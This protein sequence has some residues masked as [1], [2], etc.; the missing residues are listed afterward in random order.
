MT[1]ILSQVPLPLAY[2]VGALL[3]TPANRISVADS[4]CHQRFGTQF[5]L[6]LCL[7]DTINDAYL[8]QAE[9]QTIQTIQTIYQK[10]QQEEFYLPRLFIRLRS[11]EQISTLLQPMGQAAELL[12][13]FIFPKFSLENA[14]AYL[15]ALEDANHVS[16]PKP[17]FM[18]PV[19]EDASLLS[20][21]SRGETLEQ[22]KD[23]LQPYYQQVLNIRVGCNDLCH[24]FGLRRQLHQTIYDI[25]PVANILSDILT[26]F[27]TDYVVSAPV[28]EYFQDETELWKTGLKRELELDLLNG[29]I[30]KTVIHPSQIAV[31]N[32]GLKVSPAD[33]ADACQILNWNPDNPYYVSGGAQTQ[34]MNEYKTHHRWAQRILLLAE[35][36]GIRQE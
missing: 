34:R 9:Q 31:V 17:F 10:R 25:L 36:Y 2:H 14:S 28:W 22:L 12:T 19:L 26:V 15:A 24:L 20:L 35:Y 5:S 29:F 23:L 33:Y 18:M 30:G 8:H 21:R 32:E 1:R 3:Y 13:G 27:Q 16:R 4:I 6:A 7:E 11:P